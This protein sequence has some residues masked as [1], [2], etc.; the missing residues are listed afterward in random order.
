MMNLGE[1]SFKKDN[2][3]LKVEN[4]PKETNYINPEIFVA[5]GRVERI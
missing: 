2:S 3:V 4:L 5:F 1:K